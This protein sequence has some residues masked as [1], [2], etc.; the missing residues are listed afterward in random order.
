MGDSLAAVVTAFGEPLE[1]RRVP[2]PEL[3]EG[4]ML[5]RVEAA[6]LCGTDVHF[7]HGGRAFL[8]DKIPYI[9]GHETCGT[10]AEMRGRRTD[11]LGEPLS[12]GDRIIAAYTYCGRCFY[13]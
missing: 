2:I 7:W 8:A 5:M 10:I 9:P 4:S 13:C 1:L 12:V 11:L 3:E 6:T